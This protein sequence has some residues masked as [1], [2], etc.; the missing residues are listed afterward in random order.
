MTLRT[1]LTTA[2]LLVVLVPLLVVVALATLLLPGAVAGQRERGLVSGGRLVA[3][4]VSQLC[5]QAR[6]TAEA[7]GRAGSGPGLPAAL[8]SLVD[9]GLAD[10]VRVV[11]ADG[12][13]LGSAGTAPEVPQGGDCTA[14]EVLTGD[15]PAQLAAT[16]ELQR[17]DSGVGRAVA[18]FTVGDDRARD[19]ASK[20]GS[21][22]VVLLA[23][24]RVIARSSPVP[25]SLVRRAMSAGGTSVRADGWLAVVVEPEG[26]QPVGVL[27]LQ[28]AGPGIAIVPVALAVLVGAVALAS[29]IAYLLAR[30]T[31]RPLEEL[32]D[33]ADRV[34]EGDLSTS[35]VV[36]SR[37]EVGRLAATFNTMT[38]E[39]RRYVGAL[40]A[41]RDELQAGVDRLGA[42]LAGTHDLDR[43]LSVVL[44]AAMASTR[45]ARGAVLL[46]SE[47]RSCLELAVAQGLDVDEDL[48]LPLGVGVVGAVAIHGQAVR[49]RDLPTAPG[50]PTGTTVVA[51]PLKSSTT[52]I[53]VLLLL[54]REDGADFDELDAAVLHTFTTQAT[55]AVDN[56]LLH[57]QANLLSITD[58]MTGLWNYRYFQTTVTKEVERAARF[59]RPLALVM[60]DLDHFK[61]VNDTYGHQ[62][63]DAVL[64]EL[65]ARVR[66]QVRDVDT[67]AR[68]GGEEFVIVLP[69]TDE[70]GAA[71][72]AER[73]RVAV[74]TAPFGEPGQTPL[75]LTVSLGVA[76][77][78]DHGTGPTALLRAADDAL[79]VAK[80]EGRDAWRLAATSGAR[81][82]S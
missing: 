58:G 75:Q 9:G 12:A 37:D 71:H 30:A 66:A 25:D 11:G 46:L 36:R 77:F 69:E 14:G 52:V 54:D 26:R 51:V 68:Y 49:G 56:V 60:L 27:L 39:L 1:R 31:T 47:D 15:G 76:V 32:G 28:P 16:V 53:G 42:T 5:W 7:A 50:E 41:S 57:Q 78:P 64:V 73:I 72:A 59:G 24:E 34:A 79:Y 6:A 38:D 81:P 13:V 45:A 82:A 23:G 74:G 8:Q 3:E 20:A 55:V 17:D 18:A 61:Q 80:R 43:I 21:G 2:F 62:R 19:L 10:G 4:V 67:L 44:D 33:A 29:G 70:A 22:E 35:I 63:G 40:Q 65:A 48:R